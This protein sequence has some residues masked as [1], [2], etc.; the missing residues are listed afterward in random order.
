MEI[1]GD[2]RRSLFLQSII[3]P[4]FLWIRTDSGY[5]NSVDCHE[6]SR[7]AHCYAEGGEAKTSQV[8][9][10]REFLDICGLKLIK[11]YA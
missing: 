10:R 11:A 2:R 9:R 5:D 4:L 7:Y 8:R 3:N 6:R 1:S